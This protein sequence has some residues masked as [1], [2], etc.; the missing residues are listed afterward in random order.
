[1][2]KLAALIWWV[3]VFTSMFRLAEIRN[4]VAGV[5]IVLVILAACIISL[6]YASHH[7]KEET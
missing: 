1:M 5:G 3:G 7:L 6:V 2:I 4:E